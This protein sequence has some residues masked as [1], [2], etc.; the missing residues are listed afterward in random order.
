VN[1]LAIMMKELT[2]KKCNKPE[3]KVVK[4]EEEIKFLTMQT[5]ETNMVMFSVPEGNDEENP[6]IICTQKNRHMYK[7]GSL[8]RRKG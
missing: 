4:Q 2:E 3:R 5:K 1:T 7:G 6:C 8:I